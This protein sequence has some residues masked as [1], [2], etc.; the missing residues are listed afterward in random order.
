MMGR[1][2]KKEIDEVELLC[3]KINCP[4]I[5][6]VEKKQAYLELEKIFEKYFVEFP[7]QSSQIKGS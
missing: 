4:D 2:S 7:N 3:R 1:L 6:N 5:S